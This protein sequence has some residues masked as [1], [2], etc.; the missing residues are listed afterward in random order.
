MP[1]RKVPNGGFQGFV[2]HQEGSE[3]PKLASLEQISKLPPESIILPAVKD[4]M[5]LSIDPALT[6]SAV[7]LLMWLPNVSAFA[8]L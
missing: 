6:T 7:P 8:N 3:I 1:S 2:V 5:H 4:R